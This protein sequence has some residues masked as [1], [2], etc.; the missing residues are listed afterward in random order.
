VYARTLKAKEGSAPLLRWAIFD[1]DLQ[2]NETS[3]LISS[4][5]PIPTHA[6][7]TVSLALDQIPSK[8]KEGREKTKRPPVSRSPPT[9]VGRRERK[10]ICFFMMMILIKKLSIYLLGEVRPWAAPAAFAFDAYYYELP[11]FQKIL[12]IFINFAKL[13]I[14]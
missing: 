2:R 8:Q 9:V 4:H 1:L 12:L 3:Y 7:R 11:L 13:K 5:P 14:I 10:R 6:H